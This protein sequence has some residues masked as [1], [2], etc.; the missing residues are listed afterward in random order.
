MPGGFSMKK[1]IP[2]FLV[3]IVA[4]IATYQFSYFQQMTNESVNGPV[5]DSGA[6]LHQDPS[7]RVLQYGIYERVRGGAVVES[8]N[9]TTG[10]ALSRV[11]IQQLEQTNNIPVDKEVYFAYQYR[12]SNLSNK[13]AVIN[14][15]RILIHPEITL[16]DGTKKTGSEY[17]IKGKVKRG[18]VFA[19]DGY[20]FNED[21]ELVE[22]DWIFQIWY[23]GEMLV[24]QKFTSYKS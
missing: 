5:N 13:N 11:T 21:Y 15:K 9:T 10:K 14:L 12:L 7:G 18:E 22:G 23:E 19:F 1:F 6:V 24:E 3:I 4:V 2:V 16:P 20:A 17:M 8:K